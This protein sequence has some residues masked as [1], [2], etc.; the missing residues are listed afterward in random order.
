MAC[1]LQALKK[2]QVFEWYLNFKYPMVEITFSFAEVWDFK[3]AEPHSTT[4]FQ[5]YSG[6]GSNIVVSFK[7]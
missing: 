6:D 5:N 4:W 1:F 2:S 3:M 7:K